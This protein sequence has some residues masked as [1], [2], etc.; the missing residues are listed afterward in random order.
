MMLMKEGWDGGEIRSGAGDSGKA[1]HGTDEAS[2]DG[3]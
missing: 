1:G 2:H 3:R